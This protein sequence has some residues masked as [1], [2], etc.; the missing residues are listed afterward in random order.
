LK[1]KA[2]VMRQMQQVAPLINQL[3]S[4]INCWKVVYDQLSTNQMLRETVAITIKL[5]SILKQ[6]K[7]Q[8]TDLPSMF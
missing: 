3:I 4:R 5:Q 6:K 1:R 2:E 7:F 8:L